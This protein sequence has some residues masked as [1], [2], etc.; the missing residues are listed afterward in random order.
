MATKVA[1]LIID[2]T[3]NDKLTPGL[4]KA[5]KGLDGVSKKAQTTTRNVQSVN[6]SFTNMA[7][8]IGVAVAAFAGVIKVANDLRQVGVS[9]QRS[10][11]ALTKLSGSA[12]EAER[13]I[14]AVQDA[15]MG[16]V[17][18]GEAAAQAYQLM[19]FGL[20]ESAEE[21]EKFVRSIAIVAAVNPILGSTGEAINQIQLTLSNMSFLRLDQLGISAGAVRKRMQ[22][23][24]EETK[25]L[26]DEQAFQIAVMEGI[27]EQ[28]EILGDEL[29]E[30]GNASDRMGA[31][32][33]Q[34]KADIGLWIS[35]GI[36]PAIAGLL[37][38]ADAIDEV[39]G[40]ETAAANIIAG[41]ETGIIGE[42]ARFFGILGKDFDPSVTV[43]IDTD[44]T[45]EAEFWLA[46]MTGDIEVT[47]LIIQTQFGLEGRT[48]GLQTQFGLG[49][50]R[51]GDPLAETFNTIKD[52]WLASQ[53]TV[54]ARQD[55]VQRRQIALIS[56]IVTGG[57]DFRIDPGDIPLPSGFGQVAAPRAQQRGFA[58]VRDDFLASQQT[59]AA[60]QA[61][62]DRRQ[63]AL[64]TAGVIPIDP[65]EMPTLDEIAAAQFDLGFTDRDVTR[66]Q[67][68]ALAIERAREATDDFPTLAAKFGLGADQFDV[69][70]ANQMQEAFR[71]AGVESDAAALAMETYN[72]KIGIASGSSIVFAGQMDNFALALTDGKITVSEYI[73]EVDRLAQL[74]F[75]NID[76]VTQALIDTG[77][78]L[79]A[80]NFADLVGGE[81]GLDT[82]DKAFETTSKL[83]A[84]LG[85]I[86]PDAATS[87][88]ASPLQP[89]LDDMALLQVEMMTLQE[90]MTLVVDPALLDLG[91]FETQL[92]GIA[93]TDTN[94]P[95]VLDITTNPAT[96]SELV[97]I[98]IAGLNDRGIKVGTGAQ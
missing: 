76:T 77:D 4:R 55:V 10:E 14:T 7:A 47:P 43:D 97:D 3:V 98:F 49:D 81:G 16:T 44:M 8:S 67:G 9:A 20:A 79:A 13:W 45:A 26:S 27:N 32:L 6:K 42:V 34:G 30:V 59:A 91:D 40:K 94:V 52:D 78:A 90:S 57:I 70:V 1:S 33:R 18:T 48:A 56:G 46:F 61:L 74:D 25:D 11:L 64:P 12:Q 53:R 83:L 87:A 24:K 19:R 96:R 54:N 15:S 65:I 39:G 86:D 82:F 22:A 35:E 89:M 71:N 85:L 37:N 75:S 36:E 73:D 17:T 62:G 38:L 28:A 23:L 69:D 31:R 72:L 21:A 2:L 5:E 66:M 58:N 88:L 51:Q 84:D 68:M 93:A 60:R 92:S 29:L 95:I 50:T 80:Q 41:T 63:Q